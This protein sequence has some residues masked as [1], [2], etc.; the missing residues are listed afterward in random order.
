MDKCRMNVN[1]HCKKS[2]TVDLH[3]FSD[4]SVAV[5]LRHP[6]GGEVSFFMT[7]AQFLDLCAEFRTLQEV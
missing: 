5:N 3:E 7:Y 1:V 4:G 6:G 2:L